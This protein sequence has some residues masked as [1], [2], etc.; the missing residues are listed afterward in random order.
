M[1]LFSVEGTSLEELVAALAE[2]EREEL[3]AALNNADSAGSEGG[4]S[5][6]GDNITFPGGEAESQGGGQGG[7]QGGG[8]GEGQGGSR[9]GSRGGNG[10]GKGNK[11]NGKGNKKGGKGRGKGNR[12]N[13][14]GN[15]NNGKVVPL[16]GLYSRPN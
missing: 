7:S 2:L 1:I 15:K 5:T 6:N 12:K 9:G 11:K 16:N 3:E 8:R 4:S 13:G 14:K 10:R